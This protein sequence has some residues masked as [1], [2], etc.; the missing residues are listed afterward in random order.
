MGIKSLVGNLVIA[1]AA[2]ALSAPVVMA[3]GERAQELFLRMRSFLFYDVQW[4]TDRVR[5]GEEV[6]GTGK[7]HVFEDWPESLAKPRT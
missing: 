6:T 4:S 5:V 1:V 3:H 2:V 7:F